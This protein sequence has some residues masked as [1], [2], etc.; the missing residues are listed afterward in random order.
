MIQWQDFEEIEL[1]DNKKEIKKEEDFEEE[2][3]VI[4]QYPDYEMSR[5][6]E[7][8]RIKNRR[9]AKVDEFGRVQL[10]CKGKRSMVK[11]KDIW[12][13]MDF[14]KAPRHTEDGSTEVKDRD[15]VAE[16][17]KE[18]KRLEEESWKM[19]LEFIK[20]KEKLKLV[21]EGYDPQCELRPF[22]DIEQNTL[23][24]FTWGEPT[25]KYGYYYFNQET[26]LPQFSPY[27]GGSISAIKHREKVKE[28]VE[29]KF[30]SPYKMIMEFAAP[31]I[32]SVRKEDE[33]YI[34][35]SYMLHFC[36]CSLLGMLMSD[37]E[38]RRLVHTLR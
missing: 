13:S 17:K 18:I 31:Y 4:E 28:I 38:F 21:Y 7:V 15:E 5:T 2:F 12:D 29:S 20:Y 16:L 14:R 34:E 19:V 8:R 25:N 10:C 30:E 24:C 1:T 27:T 11:V 3:W 32:E 9:V 26:L 6:G 33:K 23:E 35:S 37:L 22:E 36:G